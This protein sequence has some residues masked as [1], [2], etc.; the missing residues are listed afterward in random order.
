MQTGGPEA[1]CAPCGKEDDLR[2]VSAKSGAISTLALTETSS[3]T[4][5][6]TCGGQQPTTL[7]NAVASLS[8]TLRKM[9]SSQMSQTE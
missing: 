4:T 3:H 8:L 7:A 1:C 2:R 5:P 9:R 6:H